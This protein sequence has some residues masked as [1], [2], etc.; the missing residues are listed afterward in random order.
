MILSMTCLIG[1]TD[2]ATRL[3]PHIA[4]ENFLITTPRRALRYSARLEERRGSEFYLLEEGNWH[5]EA[6]T[7]DVALLILHTKLSDTLAKNISESDEAS[8]SRMQ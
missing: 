1:L 4:R 7:P 5:S 3:W 8:S 6:D 2:S